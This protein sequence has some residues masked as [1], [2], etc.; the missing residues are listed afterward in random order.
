MP[1]LDL[2][3][4]FGRITPSEESPIKFN[5]SK[6]GVALTIPLFSGFETYYKTKSSNQ[7]VLAAEKLKSQ[8]LIDVNTDFKILKNKI[9]EI[10]SLISINE[11][12]LINTQKYFELTLGEYRRGIKNSSDLVGATDRLFATKKKKFELHKEL[13]ILKV[14]LE[15]IL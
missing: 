7:Q 14:K 5:E 9:N 6:F 11:K 13:E 2:T 15:N 10:A 4:A 3:Y 1:T 8:A 12:K